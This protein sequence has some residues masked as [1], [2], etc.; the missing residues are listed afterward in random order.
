MDKGPDILRE[1]QKHCS[2]LRQSVRAGS[3]RH[4]TSVGGCFTFFDIV[5]AG[6]LDEWQKMSNFLQRESRAF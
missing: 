3:I 2:Y 6:C 4:Y 1:V 5:K